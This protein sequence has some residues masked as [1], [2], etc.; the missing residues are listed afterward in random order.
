MKMTVSYEWLCDLVQDLNQ[1]S[2]EDIGLALTA[3]G[4]ET[5]EVSVLSYGKQV[6]LAEVIGLNPLGKNNHLT[7]KTS[8]KTYQ[9]VSNSKTVSIGDFVMVAPVGST[10]FGDKKVESREIDG[11]KTEALLLALENLGIESKSS[12]IAILGK[13]AKTAQ[14]FFDA[15]TALD[16]IYT[17]D[18]PGNRPD[19][20]SVRGL[21][22]ALAISFDLELKKAP[23]FDRSSNAIDKEI[24][25]QSDRCLRYSLRKISG[26]KNE[27]SSALF[28]KRLLLLGMRPIN[29]IVDL[30]NIAML[31]TGQPTH[32][33]DARAIKGNVIIRQAKAGENLTLLDEKEL[34]LTEDD[35]LICDE[36]KILALAG[37]MGGLH[38]GV[39]DDT[40]EIYLES[41]SFTN[42]WVRRSAKRLGLK[43]ES[44]L[45]FEKNI[46][47]ELVPQASDWIASCFENVTVSEFK[48][49][50]P[51]PAQKYTITCTP[52]EIRKYLGVY[53]ID[54]AF[55]ANIITKIGCQLETQTHH[56]TVHP[57]GERGDLR[58]KEDLIEEVARFY[59]YDKIPATV[60]R[61]SGISINPNQSFDEKIRPLLRGMGVHEAVTVAFRS[62]ETRTFNHITSPEAVTIMNPLNVE[63]TELRTHLF[64]G[65][66]QVV[67][68]N[69]NK[70]F[71]NNI[72][73]SEIANTFAKNGSQD[74][75]ETKKLSFIVS[76]EQNPY[77]KALNILNNVLVYAK[78]KNSTAQQINAEKLA[79][80]HPLNSFEIM[81][82]GK[83]VGF[84]GEIHP[85]LA[86]KYDLSDKKDFPAPVVC[87]IDFEIL[88]AHFEEK[89][90]LEAINE[91]P[92]MLRDI[93]L[94]VDEDAFG[95]NIQQ[96]LKT[97]HPH[98]KDV[99]FMSVF[100]N[101]KLKELK[102]KNL[103]LRLR[104]E[105]SEAM[106]AEEIDNF[107]QQLLAQY[108]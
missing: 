77:E 95:M 28:Q 14:T 75:V 11:V 71:E 66:L 61:P 100:Q 63:W 98:L 83:S 40:T 72:A 108:Q 58:I 101:H 68:T 104:F 16:A 85:E 29:S 86:E 20:L 78:V 79:F 15:Y 56:W 38:S 45:R 5:E 36:E 8:S 4:A 32:A 46:S 73:F 33:F 27:A 26:V 2:P 31:E 81:V 55:I 99:S 70:A 97:Q 51:H 107:I 54:D 91:L 3:I 94:C 25:I 80:L 17:L 6:E 50:Y 102:K 1:H 43:T 59:G 52:D 48:D 19:W 9:S 39:A 47:A 89:T 103:S 96:E 44:S 35:L 84:F 69:S 57:S 18:V 74:F 24:V 60:Y 34:T 7:L 53:E 42:V 92:P 21:A 10:I 82:N 41:A 76:R 90:P 64:D 62:E 106:N 65:L 93:T 12:D 13:D 67:K 105:S 23:T 37:I 22:R 87:E 30:T 88:K 49:L